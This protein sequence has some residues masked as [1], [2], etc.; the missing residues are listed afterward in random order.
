MVGSAEGQGPP[1]ISKH[2]SQELR[3]K[4]PG[5][6]GLFF[7]SKAVSLEKSPEAILSK[8]TQSAVTLGLN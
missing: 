1:A 8:G 3:Q 6:F 4:H 5:F 2:G 7:F